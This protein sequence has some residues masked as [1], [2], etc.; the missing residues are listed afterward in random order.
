MHDRHKKERK[1]MSRAQEEELKHMNEYWEGKMAD[2][3][4][5][6]DRLLSEMS[7]RHT[8]ECHKTRENMNSQLTLKVKESSELLNLRKMEEQMAKQK[9]YYF[10]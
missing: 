3:L 8:E 2:F 1:D 6:G 9:K 10:N 4:N 7:I 5:E